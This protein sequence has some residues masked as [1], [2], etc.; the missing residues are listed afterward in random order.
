MIR[1]LLMKLVVVAIVVSFASQASF[2]QLFR[3]RRQPGPGGRVEKLAERR[4]GFRLGERVN[5]MIQTAEA[6][7]MAPV[8]PRRPAPVR[9][10]S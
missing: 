10:R 7:S 3:P 1:Q 2:G 9:E 6:S 5:A 8:R 4:F